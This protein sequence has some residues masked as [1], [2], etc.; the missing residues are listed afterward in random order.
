MHKNQ[1]EKDQKIIHKLSWML[2]ANVWE[3]WSKNSAKYQLSKIAID[4]K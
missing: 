4:V 2:Y 3:I 1:L